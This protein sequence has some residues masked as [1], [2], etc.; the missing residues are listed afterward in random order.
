MTQIDFY[1]LQSHTPEAWYDFSCK[2]IEKIISKGNKIVVLTENIEA[3]NTLDSLLWEFRP[4]SFI[5]HAIS[6][7]DDAKDASM[8]V[9]ISHDEVPDNAKDVLLN[10]CQEIPSDYSKFARVAQVVNQEPNR[11]TALRRLYASFIERGH[12][13]NVHKLDR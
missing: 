5:P 2:L 11:L 8:P 13:V 4:E 9:I 10:L 3:A 12:S 6:G 7:S 1:V